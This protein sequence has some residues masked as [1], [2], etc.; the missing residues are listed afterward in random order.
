MSSKAPPEIAQTMCD[1]G[2]KKTQL[3]LGKMFVLAILAGV[4]IGF[5]GQLMT[6]VRVGV[7]PLLGTGFATFL[8]GSVFCGTDASCHRWC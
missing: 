1:V 5:G 6:T 3:K 4:Y 7:A 2:C 8:G